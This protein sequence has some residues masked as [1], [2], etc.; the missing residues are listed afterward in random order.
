[1]VVSPIVAGTLFGVALLLLLGACWVSVRGM[2][3]ITALRQ[4]VILLETTLEALDTRITREVK[5]R[6][7]LAGAEKVAEAK[8]LNEEASAYLALQTAPPATRLAR[9]SPMIRRR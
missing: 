7:G 9:P 2:G 3:G 5:T 8:S 1:M 6:A 4:R